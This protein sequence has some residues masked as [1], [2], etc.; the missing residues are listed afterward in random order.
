ME[1]L[2][3]VKPLYDL[4]DLSWLGSS[5]RP[6]PDDFLWGAQTYAAIV[7][8]LSAGDPEKARAALHGLNS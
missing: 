2:H 3:M 1:W 8:A 5:P 4:P 6:L 7:G